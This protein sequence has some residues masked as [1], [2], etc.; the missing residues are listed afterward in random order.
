MLRVKKVRVGAK[1]IKLIF[2]SLLVATPVPNISN[3][4][5]KAFTPL[6]IRNSGGEASH[7]SS[8]FLGNQFQCV[9]TNHNCFLRLVQTIYIKYI[10]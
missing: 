3:A 7:R 10:L 4:D 6:A 8:P 5:G 1:T 9:T 2:A